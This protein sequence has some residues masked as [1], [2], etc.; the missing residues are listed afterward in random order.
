MTEVEIHREEEIVREMRDASQ[1]DRWDK[2]EAETGRGWS[3]A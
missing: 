2:G 3:E 1:R